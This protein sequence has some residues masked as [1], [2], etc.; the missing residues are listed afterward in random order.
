MVVPLSWTVRQLTDAFLATLYG[1]A[2]REGVICYANRALPYD[3]LVRYAGKAS[4]LY[5]WGD[6]KEIVLQFRNGSVPRRAFGDICLEQ[7][8]RRVNNA[9]PEVPRW[10]RLGNHQMHVDILSL[11]L[12]RYP[13]IAA[14]GDLPTPGMV[15]RAEVLFGEEVEEYPAAGLAYCTVEGQVGVRDSDRLI[16]LLE[17]GATAWDVGDAVRS[18]ADSDRSKYGPGVLVVRG[19]I[20]LDPGRED[21]GTTGREFLPDRTVVVLY[22][23]TAKDLS[24]FRWERG[25]EMMMVKLRAY[26]HALKNRRLTADGFI[27]GRR[28]TVEV[29]HCLSVVLVTWNARLEPG[30]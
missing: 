5:E 27:S 13:I 21:G 16:I 7:L 23:I 25:L 12:G 3:E 2:A 4:S 10:L 9:V 8:V 18:L 24:Y 20:A 22:T 17:E 26:G 28:H 19:G 11:Q 6:V 15:A 30:Q 29:V 1:S 14:D